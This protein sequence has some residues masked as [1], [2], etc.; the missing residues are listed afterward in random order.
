MEKGKVEEERR[1]T[2]SAKASKEQEFAYQFYV[3]LKA[4]KSEAI[5]D[6]QMNVFNATKEEWRAAAWWLEK[7]NP[8]KYSTQ[9]NQ[10]VLKRIEAGLS[11]EIEQ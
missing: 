8:Q 2:D 6:V 11:G 5:A 7:E 10:E 9:V 3:K 1:L 4:A